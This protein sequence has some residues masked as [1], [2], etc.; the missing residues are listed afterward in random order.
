MLT[1]LSL[2]FAMNANGAAIA[3]WLGPLRT[4]L[5]PLPW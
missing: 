4:I 3:A 1:V 5:L 2:K